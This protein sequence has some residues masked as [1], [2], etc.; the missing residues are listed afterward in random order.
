MEQPLLTFKIELNQINKA[1]L[2][3]LP[4]VQAMG[5]GADCL[6]LNAGIAGHKICD[7]RQLISPL[8]LKFFIY[9]KYG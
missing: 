5:F 4:W 2:H 7:L 6:C 3:D 8:C 9:I 1:R